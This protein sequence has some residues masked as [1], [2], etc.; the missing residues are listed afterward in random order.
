MKYRKEE[1]QTVAK[2]KKLGAGKA[3]S[4]HLAQHS[5]DIKN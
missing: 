3:F 5:D 1:A 2:G 4:L